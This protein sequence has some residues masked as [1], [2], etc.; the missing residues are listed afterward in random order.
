M[1]G[2]LFL[3]MFLM[4]ISFHLKGYYTYKFFVIEEF[5]K[6]PEGLLRFS[7]YAEHAKHKMHAFG[8]F[9]LLSKASLESSSKAKG[10]ANLF[11]VVFYVGIAF[12]VGYSFLVG[13]YVTP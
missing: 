5:K 1:D 13:K 4:V 12:V 7:F 3:I 9:P 10:M 2:I 6:Q 8:F 11:L